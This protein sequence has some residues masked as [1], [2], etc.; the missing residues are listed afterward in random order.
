MHLGSRGMLVASLKE[1]SN[2]NIL[3]MKVKEKPRRNLQG[4]L[5]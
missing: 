3:G 5:V 1:T 2:Y 4:K